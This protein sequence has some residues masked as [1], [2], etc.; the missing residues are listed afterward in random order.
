MP[1]SL[2]RRSL[3]T[4][5]AALA[6]GVV[7]AAPSVAA[8]RQSSATGRSPAPTVV[9]RWNAT[10]RRWAPRPDQ[11]EF[12]VVFLSTNDPHAP[13]PAHVNVQAGDLWRRHPDAVE[14]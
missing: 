14:A 10:T 8:A 5:G 13:A 1:A 3:L 4:A 11:A 6:A 2:P 9:V 12:G 7:V